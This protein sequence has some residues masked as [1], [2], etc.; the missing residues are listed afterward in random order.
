MLNELDGLR[1]L[2]STWIFF[3]HFG[4]FLCKYIENKQIFAF[5]ERGNIP[6]NCFFLLTAFVLHHSSRK[7]DFSNFASKRDFWFG[8]IARV[9]PLYVA[10]LV[11]TLPQFYL[12]AKDSS[13]EVTVGTAF[14]TPLLLQSWTPWTSFYWN[15]VLWAI[16]TFAFFWV[17]YPCLCTLVER[18]LNSL[19]KE[20]A[21]AV[22]SY[23]LALFPFLLIYAG[24]SSSWYALFRSFPPLRLPTFIP[25]MIAC[26][27]FANYK[28]PS[29]RIAQIVAF[30]VT[31]LSILFIYLWAFFFPESDPESWRGGCE[32]LFDALFT[33]VWCV[34]LVGLSN[35]CGLIAMLLRTR[36]LVFLGQLSFSIYALQM[37]SDYYLIATGWYPYLDVPV[38][39]QIGFLPVSFATVI[40][41]SVLS[42]K[43]F[44]R[45][46]QKKLLSRLIP[47]SPETKPKPAEDQ[48]QVE[49]ARLLESGKS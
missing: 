31:D 29:H 9:Y 28:I 7:K 3:G 45:W 35:G 42:Y 20:I 8:R 17:L 18:H 23:L 47:R 41:F 4:S 14:L 1:F 39:F 34:T 33:P 2:C 37:I 15:S 19:V 38:W 46:A 25:G 32:V 21:V 22:L 16:S 48:G 11:L 27:W 40:A 13:W 5:S 30:A 24:V 43:Y 44:E 12:Y 36:V 10:S 6:L 26:K 49:R